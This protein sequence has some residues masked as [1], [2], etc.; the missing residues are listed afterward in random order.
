MTRAV[1]ECT[2][3]EMITKYSFQ[4]QH[5]LL[6]ADPS[7]G[8]FKEANVRAAGLCL[9]GDVPFAQVFRVS[10]GLMDMPLGRSSNTRWDCN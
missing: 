9:T 1:A 6:C 4:V 7:D 10:S 2:T 3:K 5:K 8:A